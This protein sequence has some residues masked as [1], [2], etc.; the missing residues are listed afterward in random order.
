MKKKRNRD[1][2]AQRQD[3]YIKKY[4]DKEI[5]RILVPNINN[6]QSTTVPYV[7]N[8]DAEEALSDCLVADPFADRSL[9]F[10]GLTGS[11][12]TTIL[13][14]VFRLENNANEAHLFDSTIVIPI[15]FNRAQK[16]A[17]IAFLTSIRGAVDCIC[18]R[19]Q[20]GYPEIDNQE[21]F[22]FVKNC[23]SDFLFFDPY[24]GPSLPFSER[25]R[26]FADKL[27]ETYASCQLQY[28]MGHDNCELNLAVLVVDNIE[29][30]S[31][32]N[33]KNGCS[34]YLSPIIEALKLA[35]CIKQRAKPTKWS[36]NLVI[37]CR[38]FAW[39]IMTGHH[40]V[41]LDE[42][43]L[44][45]SYITTTEPYDLYKPV[46]VNSIVKK[47]D[48]VFARKQRDPIKWRT[49]VKVVNTVL[50]TMD[51]TVGDFI[52]KL[53]LK[54]L[55]KSLA[56]M[57]QVV[58]NKGLQRKPN[59]EIQS[60]AFQIDSVEQFDLTRVNI[61]RV[62]GLG[63][64]KFYSNDYSIIPNLLYNEQQEGME[65]YVLLTLKYFLI[66]CDYSEPHW[67]TSVSIQ[68][69]YNRIRDLFGFSTDETLVGPFDKAV[70]FLIRNRLLLRSADQQQDEVLGLSIKEIK[71]I[72]HVYVSSSAIALWNELSKSSALFQLYIDDIWLDE[73]SDYFLDDGN[74]IEHCLE[75]LHTL[76]DQE[77]RIFNA[78]RNIS[79]RHVN[80]Y[81]NCFD[82]TPICSQ[83]L[84]G[85]ICS[86]NAIIKSG[87]TT[88]KP[89]ID[90]A[91][92]ALNKANEFK[93][94]L[95]LWSRT[96]GKES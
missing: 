92:T 95:D 93:S 43:A 83:L 71:N 55:R 22:E 16:N 38:H 15:D 6:I 62:I 52:L 42:S 72:E 39:R 48:E 80:M 78:A 85:L 4:F 2:V 32:P 28:V 34:R 64:K 70:H 31:L 18:K 3:G 11:G 17:Q 61:I 84:S 29:A 49:A 88:S 79:S 5:H 81:K 58:L 44:L 26:L 21:F 75:Y 41:N 67:E 89:R 14:H 91:R 77:K 65:L 74:N 63:N 51:A 10:T 7:D 37:A 1:N 24:Y 12:K 86:L 25:L 82:S 69:F 27:P 8:I 66:Q 57:S 33:S 87:D 68:Y 50:S 13:R 73:S 90:K 19:F 76:F 30:F 56:L 60:G 23:R 45:Q 9:L 40:D 94:T 47:R 59:E 54:D 96:R 36:F 35:E 46:S 20:I 53:E